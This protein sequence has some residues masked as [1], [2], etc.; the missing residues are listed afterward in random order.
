LHGL[1]C[2][3]V[4]DYGVLTSDAILF[5]SNNRGGS[6]HKAG[7]LR[8]ALNSKSGQNTSIS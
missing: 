3:A 5:A 1:R 6:T 4:I 8:L 2:V 7:S